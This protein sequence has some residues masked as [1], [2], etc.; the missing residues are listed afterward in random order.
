MP[1]KRL[2]LNGQNKTTSTKKYQS[3]K[4]IT[5]HNINLLPGIHEEW[6]LSLMVD[7]LVI[8]NSCWFPGPDNV[9]GWKN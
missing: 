2:V 1:S 7:L 4:T 8:Y 6:S 3:I 5:E 9:L